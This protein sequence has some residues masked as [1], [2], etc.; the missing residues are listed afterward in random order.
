MKKLINWLKWIDD[1]LIS[2]LLV[3]FIL[4]I[5][6]YPKLPFHFITYTYVS[7]RLEDLYV[8]FLYSVFMIQLLR[9]KIT[10]NKYLLYPIIFF[11]L[12]VFASFLYHVYLVKDFPYR[13]LAFLHTLRR[14]EYMGIFFV[15]AAL[16]NQKRIMYFLKFVVLVFFIVAVYGIGQ[17]FFG[18]PA[19]QTMNP[20]YAKGY[21]LVLTPDA[22]ISSTFAGHY[23]FAAYVMFFIP[24]IL[25]FYLMKNNLAYLGIF[26]VSL[27]ALVLTASRASYGSYLLSTFPFLLYL[28][29]F[30]LL[31]FILIITAALTLVSGPLTSRIF[32]TFQVKKIFVNE[33]TGQ[34]LVPQNITTK[35]V[36][37]GSLYYKLRSATTDKKSEKLV[38]GELIN[39]IR[40]KASSEGKK[41]TAHDE[42]VLLASATAALTPIT[43]VVSDIS[44]ATRIQI[45]WPRAIQ[46][47]LSNPILGKGPATI[48]EATDNDYLRLIG[49]FGLL[50]A[51]TF[52]FVLFTI[53]QIIRKSLSVVEKNIKLI[54]LGFLFGSLGLL[55]NSTYFDL[56]EASKIAYHFWLMAG[57]IVG[58]IASLQKK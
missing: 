22:R 55:I 8:F 7:I 36:P 11:W 4:I 43:T 27:F 32:R 25:A 20:E 51:I 39:K 1:N 54:S 16:S 35:E 38:A 28:R 34:V 58:N 33:Q 14:V 57:L 12:A 52:T 48:T 56:F 42:S 45:E 29:K 21:I 15:A 13:Q 18:W 19:V 5:P 49:E 40:K 47:F 26:L 50:G 37:A 9:K 30:K 46:A 23:D 31:A 10:L 2:I 17:K 53:F 41:L 24:L 6:L 44:F 3:G